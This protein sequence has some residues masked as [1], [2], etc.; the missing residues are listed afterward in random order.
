MRPALCKQRKQASGQRWRGKGTK[1]GW[2]F[3]ERYNLFH[4]GI[5]G[6]STDLR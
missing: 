2:S 4:W 6:K 3:L 1:A 5:L